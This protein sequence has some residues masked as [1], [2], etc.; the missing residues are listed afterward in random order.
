MTRRFGQ[1]GP[2]VRRVRRSIAPLS[3]ALASLTLLAGVVPAGAADPPTLR[4]FAAQSEVTVERDRR[5]NVF[6]DPGMWIAPV[7]GAFELRATRPDYDSPVSLVQ[8]DADTGAVLRTLSPQLM[9]EWNGLGGFVHV[10]ITTPGGREVFSGDFTFCPNTYFRARISDDGPLST[11][12]PFVCGG[13]PFTKGTVWGIED[14]WAVNGVSDAYGLF[15]RATR[16]RYVVTASID[17]AYVDAFGIAPEDAQA[18]VRVSV[19]DQGGLGAGASE[20]TG[21]AYER[22]PRV[23]TTTVP[24]AATVPDLVALPAWGITTY[25]RRGRDL[26]AFNATEWNAGP[27]PLVVEGFRGVDD[28]FMDAYQYFLRDGAAV[29][30]AP[31]GR[32]EFHPAH[33]HWHFEE[34]T[35]YSL[36]DAESGQVQVSGK[37]SWCLANTDA[38]DLSVDGA[39]AQTS[40]SSTSMPRPARQLSRRSAPGRSSRRPT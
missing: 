8:T 36:L 3:V 1:E 37:Q 13:N 19:I 22:G 32:M 23:P 31:I 29:E 17:A 21:A 40:S 2:P 20:R 24:D 25:H 16:A 27:G 15:F 12:Y 18:R 7:G 26:L 38:I 28:D 35:R 11:V 34:F 4:L 33:Q 5:G 30:R 14:G 9:D 39:Q 6:L 10:R